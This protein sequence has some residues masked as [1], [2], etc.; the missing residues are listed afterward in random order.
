MKPLINTSK[1]LTETLSTDFGKVF[2]SQPKGCATPTN[3]STL[4]QVVKAC[5]NSLTPIIPR[6]MSHSASG[7]CLSPS[8]VVIDMKQ[9]ND[10]HELEFDGEKGFVK[11][12]AGITWEKL[13]KA[14]LKQQATPPVL[15]DWQ[16]LTVGGTVSTG[17]L[18]FMSHLTGIQA[19][20]VDELEVV[21]GMGE[22]VTCSATKNTDLFKLVRGGLG[23]YGIIATV[24]IQLKKAPKTMHVH[25][26]LIQNTEEFSELM[27]SIR[28]QH[29]FECIHSFLI[30]HETN[31]FVKKF[32]Q[33]FYNTNKVQFNKLSDKNSF[34]Y[35]V[36]VV[37]YGYDSEINTLETFVDNEF[38]C[39]EQ[40]DFYEYVTKEPPLIA[41]QK[42]KGTTA[43]P[44]LAVFIPVNEFGSFM[45]LF[46]QNHKSKDMGEGPVLIMPISSKSIQES[47]FV[48]LETDFYFIGIL[49]N[50]FPNTK[51]NIEHLTTLNESVYEK[52]LSLGGK[53][54]PCDSLR[55]PETNQ[56]WQTHFGDQWEFVN[57][58]K[59]QYDPKHIFK[60][61]LSIHKKPL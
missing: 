27:D 14:C 39:Y 55:F 56:E 9:M 54:Y 41:T 53:R 61:L 11:V 33:N 60:S 38:S 4:T 17:G 43:H 44:E 31:E 51:E 59:H 35:F 30:P 15:T 13:I 23:Q 57:Q 22:L 5:Y 19:D 7:Q 28:G 46:L 34:S 21:T 18:G 50:A 6:G 36:E 29:T 52:A 40:V 10:I 2:Y 8:G 3:T 26:T 24:K 1:A 32:G 42:E 48:A 16:K 45:D 49:R 58:G 20:I 12:D 25:K 37:Q 47:A